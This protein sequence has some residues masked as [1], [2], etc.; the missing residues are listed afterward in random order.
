MEAMED[1]SGNPA[2]LIFTR[3]D[4]P[5]SNFCVCRVLE[6]CALVT[7]ES[8]CK[9]QTARMYMRRIAARAPGSYLV[10]S[11]ASRRVL[12]NVDERSRCRD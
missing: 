1:L 8:F 5:S 12:G 3:H 2:I 11:K 6:D 10:F 7:I 9:L 4:A